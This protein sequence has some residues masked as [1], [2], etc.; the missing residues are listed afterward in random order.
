MP[1][2][3]PSDE[4]GRHL[5]GQA[6]ERNRIHPRGGERR[7]HVGG[8]RPRGDERDAR[9]AGG[10]GIALGRVAGALLVADED[11][12]DLVLLDDLVVD[13]QARPA[14]IAEDVL[15]ALVDERLDDHLRSGH[16][17]SATRSAVSSRP[18]F[19]PFHLATSR[20]FVSLD[21]I[22]PIKKALPGLVCAPPIATVV[23]PSWRCAPKLR[24]RVPP[25]CR[26]LHSM[27]ATQNRH[28]RPPGQSL[29]AATPPAGGPSR[30]STRVQSAIWLRNHV[31]W[32]LA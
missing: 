20:P 21:T 30:G 13:R 19:L 15:D 23:K 12:L 32:R 28:D 10:A 24:G 31:I 16:L 7:H 17:R 11:V 8:A 4:G 5:A 22:R 9:L 27:R 6:D 2:V 29:F 14:R 3:S 25:A 1:T 26:L 18:V